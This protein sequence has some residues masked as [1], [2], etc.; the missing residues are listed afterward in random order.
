MRFSSCDGC[1]DCCTHYPF[2]PIFLEEF[3]EIYKNFP[4]VFARI[5]NDKFALALLYKDENR[6]R[7]LKDSACSIYEQ[8]PGACKIYPI[9]PINTELY[10]DAS[11]GATNYNNG[12]FLF[13]NSLPNAGFY[14][15]RL[16]NFATKRAKLSAFLETIW[17][18]LIPLANVQGVEVLA[19]TKDSDNCFLK[20]HQ[21][22]IVLNA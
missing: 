15:H 2:V 6:C 5:G 12:T 14:H 4:I 17:D 16:E 22:S 18:A 13:E 8:R 11:C 21:E 3:E 1:V 9:I 10:Y 20:W 19:F 7:Y